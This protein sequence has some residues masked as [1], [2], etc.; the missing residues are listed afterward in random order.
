MYR[1]GVLSFM[2]LY[3]WFGDMGVNSFIC[4]ILL[5][6]GLVKIIREW[7][8]LIIVIS[9]CWFVVSVDIV[10]FFKCDVILFGII[11]KRFG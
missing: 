3:V 10:F 6:R 8:S 2:L 9:C 1:F 4:L 11:M 7:C 5:I